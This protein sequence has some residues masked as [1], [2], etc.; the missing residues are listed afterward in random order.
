MSALISKPGITPT[1]V[2]SIPIQWSMTWFRE[3][4]ASYLKGADVRNAVG[5]SGITVTGNL[6][7]PFATI[8]LNAPTTGAATAT[9]AATNKPG[10]NAG[11]V[12]WIPVVVGGQTRYLPLFG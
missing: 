8:S 2:L 5:G 4:I 7:S 9:F 1:S 11:V 12:G 3:F 10:A 6:T